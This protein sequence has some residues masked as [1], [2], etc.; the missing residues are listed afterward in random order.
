MSNTNDSV[1]DTVACL[2]CHMK[3]NK[4]TW[5]TNKRPHL[6]A[7]VSD[8]QKMCKWRSCKECETEHVFFFPLTKTLISS[9]LYFT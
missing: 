9:V 3:P 6:T 4:S 7:N 8:L 5:R 2:P 1:I